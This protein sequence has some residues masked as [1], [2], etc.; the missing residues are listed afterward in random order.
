MTKGRRKAPR[1]PDSYEWTVC[2][3]VS[4]VMQGD[5]DKASQY[6][7]GSCNT[8]SFISACLRRKARRSMSDLNEPRFTL[9]K[10]RWF[11]VDLA[12]LKICCGNGGLFLHSAKGCVLTHE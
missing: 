4:T 9:Q 8:I 12:L 6:L 10:E 2:G 5:A 7:I 3:A 11:A 1:P